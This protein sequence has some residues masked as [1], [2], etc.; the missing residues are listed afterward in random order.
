MEWQKEQK[1]IKNEVAKGEYWRQG[2]L[3]AEGISS[4]AEGIEG[5]GLGAR[6]IG[7]IGG[8]IKGRGGI[9]D[10]GGR[11][12]WRYWRHRSIGGIGGTGAL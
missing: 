11:G 10:I 12:H 3:E 5:R 9:G 2:A 8:S 6:G 1:R 7:R 4:K